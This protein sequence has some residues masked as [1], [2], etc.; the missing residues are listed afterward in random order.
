MRCLP[1]GWLPL[2]PLALSIVALAAPAA[3]QQERAPDA[4]AAP[5]T[6]AKSW[7]GFY[8]GGGIGISALNNRTVNSAGGAVTTLDGAGGTGVLASVYGGVDYQVLP[9]AVVGVLVE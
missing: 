5:F 6:Y 8:V 1:P 9:K 4:G 2:A 3:A 7:A